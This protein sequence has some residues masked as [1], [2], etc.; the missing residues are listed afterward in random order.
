MAAQVGG[1]TS[2]GKHQYGLELTCRDMRSIRFSHAKVHRTRTRPCLVPADAM[3]LTRA[4]ACL[5]PGRS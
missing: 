2:R 3:A 5:H 1:Q 4:P